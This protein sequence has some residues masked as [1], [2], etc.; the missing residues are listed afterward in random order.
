LGAHQDVQTGGVD[1][2]R[3]SQVD[4][5]ASGAATDHVVEQGR[6]ARSGAQVELA[7]HGDHRSVGPPRLGQSQVDRSGRT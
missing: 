7:A 5:D 3:L 1:E 4:D 2:R 6:R